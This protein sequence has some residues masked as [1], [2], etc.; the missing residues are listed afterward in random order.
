MLKLFFF[1]SK[2]ILQ[3]E[4]HTAEVLLD[5]FLYYCSLA[6]VGREDKCALLARLVSCWHEAGLSFA[7]LEAAL[8]AARDPALLAVIIVTLFCP[9]TDLDTEN[10]GDGPIER[11]S[12]DASNLLLPHARCS[13]PRGTCN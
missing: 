12:C 11:Y 9:N 8:L 4:Q 7:R 6:A 10:G 3:H 1:Y 2:A 13:G 5:T